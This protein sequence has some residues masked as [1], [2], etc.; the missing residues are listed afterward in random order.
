VVD[1]PRY[2]TKTH[3]DH[4]MRSLAPTRADRGAGVK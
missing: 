1:Y 4:G 2:M 3:H